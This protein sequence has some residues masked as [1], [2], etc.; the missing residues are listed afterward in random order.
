MRARS[1]AP[2]PVFFGLTVALVCFGLAM[3]FSA[4]AF[5]AEASG[6][7]PS[8]F[9]LRQAL[10]A[11]FGVGL[12]MV[13]ARFDYRRFNR[14]QVMAVLVGLSL[15]ALT[16]THLSAPLNNTSRWLRIGGFSAQPSEFVKVALVLILAH[17]MATRAPDRLRGLLM[18]LL[19]IGALG[20]LVFLQR[21]LGAATLLAL[22]GAAVLGIGG[23]RFRHLALLG[24]ACAS[25]FA[26]GVLADGYRVRRI[27]T[28]LDPFK[29]PLGDG[30]Q[31]IQSLIALGVGGVSGVG[32]TGSEQ[33][34]LYLPV[35]HADFIFSVIGEEFGFLGASLVVL[36]F[37][38]WAARGLMIAMRS[39]DSFGMLVGAGAVL[40][41]GLQAFLHISVTVGLLPTTGLPLPFISAGGSALV[42]ALAASGLV[43]SVSQE[44]A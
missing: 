16:A 31:L 38:A 12:M 9:V 5:V 15:L 4:S 29:D 44:A 13:L 24:A 3:L 34:M 7:E 17:Q 10:W 28:F 37:G 25:L 43:L 30:F 41:V 6:R 32:F 40:A 27:L 2:D 36:A 20:W 1:V 23:A 19:T 39:P 22:I 8:W 26:L 18:P 33:K 14:P 42:S 11:V 21:D 35:P